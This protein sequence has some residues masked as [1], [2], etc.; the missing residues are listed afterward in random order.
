MTNVLEVIPEV[1]R[2]TGIASLVSQ[3]MCRCIES[4]D[5]AIILHCPSELL[6]H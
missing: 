4:T 1:N 6:V 3:S 5:S 2:S